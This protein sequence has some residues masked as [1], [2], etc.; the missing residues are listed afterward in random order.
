MTFT[1][2]IL[3]AKCVHSMQR[4]PFPRSF[5]FHEML[6]WSQKCKV[7]SLADSFKLIKIKDEHFLFHVYS[8][9][10]VTHTHVVLP[11]DVIIDR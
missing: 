5:L 8:M 3:L 1:M 2:D 4:V 9:K 11:F 7:K 6:R 10:V